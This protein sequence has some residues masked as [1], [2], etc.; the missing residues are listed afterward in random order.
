MS[1]AKRL[2]S[3]PVLPTETLLS[4]ACVPPSGLPSRDVFTLQY[5]P[6]AVNTG[7]AAAPVA[8]SSSNGGADHEQPA[9]FT[10][11]LTQLRCDRHAFAALRPCGHIFSERALKEL[12]GGDGS[13]SITA[14][15]CPT[16][17][18]A[19]CAADDVVTLFPDAQQLESLRKLL[20]VRRQ[21][22]KQKRKKRKRAPAEAADDSQRG[23]QQCDQQQQHE[24]ERRQQ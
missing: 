17:G 18:T 14:V 6:A 23:E 1:L 5:E 2:P 20:P 22:Q 15:T 21:Q 16:C 9:P 13:G 11:P 10:C 3:L 12:A 19:Y 8:A 4:H 7:S 24:Q